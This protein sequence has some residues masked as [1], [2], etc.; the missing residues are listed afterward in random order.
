MKKNLLEIEDDYYGRKKI[1]EEEIRRRREEK[2]K[3][4]RY[5]QLTNMIQRPGY[6]NDKPLDK[7][8]Y[9]FIQKYNN[10]LI[11][12]QNNFDKIGY[13]E[14][15]NTTKVK[16]QNAHGIVNRNDGMPGYLDQDDYK[17]YYYDINE[18]KGELNFE[19]P[20]K[21][22]KHIGKENTLKRTFRNEPGY[23]D[24]KGKFYRTAS[25]PDFNNI[26][27]ACFIALYFLVFE[28]V[29]LFLIFFSISV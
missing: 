5:K 2:A 24:T 16:S 4:Q 3:L 14:E 18:G 22:H 12:K 19:R 10:Y 23:E 27:N 9:E 6:N 13:E 11:N 20:L 26:S 21:I 28:L 7:I 25:A 17:L 15:W 1:S 8:D 29:I